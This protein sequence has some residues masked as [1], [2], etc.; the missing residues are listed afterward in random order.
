MKTKATATMSAMLLWAAPVLGWAGGMRVE[1]TAGPSEIESVIVELVKAETDTDCDKDAASP[2]ECFKQRRLKAVLERAKQREQQAKLD[3]FCTAGAVQRGCERLR[4]ILAMR[5][6]TV[7]DCERL[8]AVDKEAAAT[9]PFTAFCGYVERRLAYLH[10]YEQK[11]A[12]ESGS[13]GRKVFACGAIEARDQRERE[14]LA[15]ERQ[16]QDAKVAATINKDVGLPVP[17]PILAL[18]PAVAKR[19][20]EGRPANVCP[21]GSEGWVKLGS[22]DACVAGQPCVCRYDPNFT[23]DASVPF[24]SGDKWLLVAGAERCASDLNVSR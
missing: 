11:A 6:V 4:S 17:A 1:K 14:R 2:R 9:S 13:E 19:P 3:A 22:H 20:V 23:R 24:C 16:E 18:K 21:S 10:D 7:T 12:C 15:K 8:R 5:P